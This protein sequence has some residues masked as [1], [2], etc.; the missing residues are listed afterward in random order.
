MQGMSNQNRI[1]SGVREGGQFATTARSE[2][3]VSLMAYGVA[4]TFSPGDSPAE[5]I[6][7]IEVADALASRGM[8]G[9]LSRSDHQAPAGYSPYALVDAA[10]ETRQVNFDHTTSD[11]NLG[12]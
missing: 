8:S 12:G 2:P 5:R 9:R 11:I 6:E 4:P 3:A 7:Q 10:G 1:Q